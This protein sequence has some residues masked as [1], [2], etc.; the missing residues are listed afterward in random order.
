MIGSATTGLVGPY[1]FPFRWTFQRREEHQRTS[2]K[3]ARH[4]ASYP[5]GTPPLKSLRHLA[6]QLGKVVRLHATLDIGFDSLQPMFPGA[7]GEIEIDFVDAGG[8]DA[9]PRDGTRGLFACWRSWFQDR[10]AGLQR[11]ALANGRYFPPPCVLRVHMMADETLRIVIG[12][13]HGFLPDDRRYVLLPQVK[14]RQGSAWLLAPGEP[15]PQQASMR[16]FLH[17][18]AKRHAGPGEVV[19]GIGTIR[20]DAKTAAID[21]REGDELTAMIDS[22]RCDGVALYRHDQRIGWG[23]QVELSGLIRSRMALRLRLRLV[24]KGFLHHPVYGLA[25][26][27]YA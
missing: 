3:R 21:L 17:A 1:A 6:K 4:L 2:R 22:G 19:L 12:Y 11:C 24:R 15:V 13:A 5:P 27:I 9:C 7:E 8:I 20:P 25:F 14:T 23:E 16:D 26:A 10:Y 18:C